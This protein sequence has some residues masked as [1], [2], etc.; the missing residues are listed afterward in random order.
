MKLRDDVM[1]VENGNGEDS[2]EGN[3]MR[4]KRETEKIYIRSIMQFQ[5]R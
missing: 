5:N 2:I 4:E 3:E 1:I